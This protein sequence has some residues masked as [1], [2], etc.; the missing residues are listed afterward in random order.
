MRTERPPP[1][2]LYAHHHHHHDDPW[3]TPTVPP[4]AV[5]LRCILGL[6]LDNQEKIMSDMTN[7]NAAMADLKTSFADLATRMDEN[8]ALLQAG[9]AGSDQAQID[10]ATA[11][12]RQTIEDM[13]A[14]ATRDTPAAPATA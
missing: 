3:G 6:F 1:L 13:H 7:F 4:W 5:E 2:W 8:F 9:H 14:L 11:T 10:T 12:I